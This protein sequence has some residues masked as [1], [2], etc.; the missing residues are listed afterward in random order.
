MQTYERVLLK[1]LP[2]NLLN[3]SSICSFG[4]KPQYS[5]GFKIPLT[6]SLSWYAVPLKHL[7]RDGFT[8]PY[9]EPEWYE[10]GSNIINAEPCYIFTPN[11][12]EILT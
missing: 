6:T 12:V 4:A 2:E 9:A 7:I 11:Q 8:F 1:V 3:S 10:K 5:T